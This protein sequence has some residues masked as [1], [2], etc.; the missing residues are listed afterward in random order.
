MWIGCKECW[1]T[2]IIIIIW[3]LA[4]ICFWKVGKCLNELPGS[5]ESIE[6]PYIGDE[7]NN[8]FSTSLMFCVYLPASTF[9]VSQFTRTREWKGDDLSHERV[10][11][12]AFSLHIN[13]QRLKILCAY[14]ERIRVNIFWFVGRPDSWHRPWGYWWLNVGIFNHVGTSDI[15]IATASL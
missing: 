14:C 7:F 1:S 10:S 3:M 4:C 15:S 5:V 8:V 2:W 12:F 13:G 6:A 11:G 9:L